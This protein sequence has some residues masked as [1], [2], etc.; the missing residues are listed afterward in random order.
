[1]GVTQK[2]IDGVKEIYRKEGKEISEHEAY[3][4]ASN[5]AGLAELLYELA[6][7]DIQRKN[8]LKKEPDGFPVDGQY[9]CL[10]CGNGIDPQTG[11][12]DWYGQTCLRCRKAIKS[13]D[14]P[15]YICTDRDSYFSMWKLTS[16]LK[17]RTPA[18]KKFI[19][20][21]RL[22]ARTVLNDNGTVH[23]YIFLKK[24]NPDL[25]EKWDPVQKSLN[26]HRDKISEKESRKR[27]AEFRA[28]REKEMRK[29]SKC[30]LSKNG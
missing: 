4:A 15:T 17:V 14:I 12:Y 10:V 20:D 2:T 22:K 9:T 26:R 5:L 18:I 3:D 7:K 28:G 25:I 16:E 24:E 21:G 19:K 11:W 30:S 1:M 27:K 29:L 23:T 8:R 13:G 6:V